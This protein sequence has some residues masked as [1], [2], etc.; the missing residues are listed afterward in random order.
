M[1]S[2]LYYAQNIFLKRLISISYPIPFQVILFHVIPFYQVLSYDLISSLFL[3]FFLLV[4]YCPMS[5]LL[6]SSIDF[7]FHLNCLFSFHLLSLV[8][9]LLFSSLLF[10]SNLFYS[11]IPSFFLC[12][13]PVLCHLFLS[14]P[15]YSLLNLSLIVS[16]YLSSCL[17]LFL[18]LFLF[19]APHIVSFL[20]PWSHLFSSHPILS[21]LMTGNAGILAF[22]ALDMH[23]QERCI[24][25]VHQGFWRLES[26]KWHTMQ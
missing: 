6:I 2:Y 5:C 15:L 10:S 26:H 7:S 13:S 8:S 23:G 25:R 16:S 19:Y 3:I 17:F 11:F 24:I 18:F 9:S 22:G 1:T 20:C 12:S 21:S 4:F 14:L